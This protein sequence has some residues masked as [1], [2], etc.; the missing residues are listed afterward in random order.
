LTPLQPLDLQARSQR[1][2]QCIA[3]QHPRRIAEAEERLGEISDEAEAYHQ[4]M[5]RTGT[6]DKA[7]NLAEWKRGA[8]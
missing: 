2:Q 4:A 3:N 1:Q 7:D 8:Y 6:A 5:E